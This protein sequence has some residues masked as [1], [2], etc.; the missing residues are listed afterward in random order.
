MLHSFIEEEKNLA[1]RKSN[2]ENRIRS[3]PI[4]R[5]EIGD[6]EQEKTLKNSLFFVR[7]TKGLYFSFSAVS[8]VRKNGE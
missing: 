3:N 1:L 7:T 6:S 4:A 5:S 2:R 8:K